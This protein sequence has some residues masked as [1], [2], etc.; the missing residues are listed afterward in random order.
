[1]DET[2]TIGMREAARLRQRERALGRDVQQHLLLLVMLGFK[3][4]PASP[5]PGVHRWPSHPGVHVR[6]LDAHQVVALRG[7]Q[8][9]GVDT[10]QRDRHAAGS[11]PCGDAWQE[12]YAAG[13]HQPYTQ[14]PQG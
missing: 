1:M 5:P 11:R 9:P 6:R 13:Y 7:A 2:G 10:S 4:S 12:H 3:V 8:P 14:L